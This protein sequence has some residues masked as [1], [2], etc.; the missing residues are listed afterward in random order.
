[1]NCITTGPVQRG[2]RQ[3]R[4]GLGFTQ[5]D[6]VVGLAAMLVVAALVLIPITLHRQKSRL[7]RCVGNLQ[8]I[9]RAVIQFSADHSGEL[10]NAETPRPGDLWWWYKEDIKKYAGI[11]EES[12]LN[13]RGFAC[14]V[15]RGYTDSLPFSKNPRFDFGSY[16]F[17]G[18][19]LRG[20]PNISGMKVES[21]H[22]P[23]RTLLVMEWTAHAPLSWHRSRTGNRNAPFY[24]NA[25]SVVGFVDGHVSLSPIYYDGFHAAFTRDPIPG[26]TYQYSGR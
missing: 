9:S 6:L 24:S 18:V 26:Y 25:E 23:K 5:T 13:D 22:T 7:T 12:S 3:F 14:P 11:V 21:I 17:N 10:P 15:D 16:V 20:S 4:V 2:L 8:Q 1:M 19:T